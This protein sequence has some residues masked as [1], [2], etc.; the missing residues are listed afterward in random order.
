MRLTGR[1]LVEQHKRR[2]NPLNEALP[3]HE[4]K[5]FHW[6]EES[7]TMQ[8]YKHV[9]TGRYIH[10]DGQDGTFHSQDRGTITA[11]QALDYAMP[12]GQ[13]HSQSLEIKPEREISIRG[14]G[15][16]I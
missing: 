3:E 16:G 2:W 4:A 13:K 8:S 6:Q 7:G 1:E 11:K 12:E 5:Q 9:Q 15:L 10:I 14:Y